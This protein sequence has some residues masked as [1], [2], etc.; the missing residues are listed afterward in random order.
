MKSAE[1][2]SLTFSAAL[3][4]LHCHAEAG[5][6]APTENC[7]FAMHLGRPGVGEQ[8]DVGVDIIVSVG[9]EAAVKATPDARR[10]TTAGVMLPSRSVGAPPGA[11]HVGASGRLAW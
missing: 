11:G 7:A 9:T 4:A 2:L 10:A 5:L 6:I 3:S 1:T 8:V